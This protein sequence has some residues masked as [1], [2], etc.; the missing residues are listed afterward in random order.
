MNHQTIHVERNKSPEKIDLAFLSLVLFMC[1]MGLTVLYSGSMAFGERVFGDPLYFLK[2]Q[3]MN[4]LVGIAAMTLFASIKLEFIRKHLPKIV[5]ATLIMLV[6]PLLPGIG[7]HKNGSSRWFAVGS[8]TFQPSELAKMVIVLYLAH[9]FDKK[10]DKFDE[11]SISL[12]PAALITALMVGIIYLQNDFST[13]LFVFIVALSLFF[14]A[15]VRIRMFLKLAVLIIPLV[16]FMI[17][18][19]EYRMERVLSYLYP[20]RDPLGSGYQVNAAI[21]A[22]AEGGFWGR[23]LGNGI[24]KISGIP[25]VQ[26]DFIFAVWAEEMGFLGILAYFALLVLFT[27]RGY[28]ISVKSKDRFRSLVAFGSTSVLLFQS[29]MNT[30]VVVRAFPAT[31][32]PLPFFSSGGSSLLISL[33]L[34]GLIIN[35]SRS[36]PEGEIKN[37]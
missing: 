30:G 17:V 28:Y 22:I 7:V 26:S 20:E 29:I 3:A 11:P 1:A 13:A 21:S 4:A 16:I 25:E 18:T 23:G 32:I 35:V 36:I 6:L 37:G 24:R 5:I 8:S 34:C 19:E 33:C 27:V 31:G 15:G 12:Y 10:S 2:K 14:M 9:I